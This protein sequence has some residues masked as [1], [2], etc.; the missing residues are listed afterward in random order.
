M[1]RK[2]GILAA[3]YTAVLAINLDTT[4][5][6]VALPSIARDLGSGTRDLQWVVDGY[7]TSNAYPYSQSQSMTD[8]INGTDTGSFRTDQVNYI[9]NSV[10]ATVDAYTGKVTLYAWDTTDPVLKTW[11]KIFPTSL[12]PVSWS[13]PHAC[14][15]EFGHVVSVWG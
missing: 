3:V 8:S 12:Q 6:N 10:K 14:S 15:G 5:V 2:A 1:K 4:I 9:R 7:T 13:S 11:Q